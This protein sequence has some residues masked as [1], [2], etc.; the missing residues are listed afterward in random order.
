MLSGRKHSEVQ[1][2][3]CRGPRRGQAPGIEDG[4]G[5]QVVSRRKRAAALQWIPEGRHGHGKDFG[6]GAG[7]SRSHGGFWAESRVG[8]DLGLDRLRGVMELWEGSCAGLGKAARPRPLCPG[9]L[10]AARAPW[11]G[12]TQGSQG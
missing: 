2:S 1:S 6:D 11:I 7:G 9:D 3:K 5:N 4:G 10:G 8:A 12:R